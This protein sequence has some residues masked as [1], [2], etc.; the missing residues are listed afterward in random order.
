MKAFQP[1]IF[2]LA[3]VSTLVGYLGPWVS[4]PVSGLTITGLDLPEYV[5]FLPAV[6]SGS[7]A[8]WREGFYLPP[9]AVS[10]NL[11]LFGFRHTLGLPNWV[12]WVCPPAAIAIAALLLPPAWTPGLLLTPEFRL[13]SAAMVGCWVVAAFAPIAARL[14]LLLAKGIAALAVAAALI[15]PLMLFLRVLPEIRPLYNAPVA[16]GWGVVAMEAGLI[17][18]LWSVLTVLPAHKASS[19]GER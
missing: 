16:I 12:K 13:Q 9:F 1:W 4:H 3:V 8:I 10:L 11:A 14:Q 17:G 6:R 19:I 7:I 15:V 5:K 2:L 18:L